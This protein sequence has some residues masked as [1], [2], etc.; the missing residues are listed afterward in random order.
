MTDLTESELEEYFYL[1]LEERLQ[2]LAMPAGVQLTL[3]PEGSA[4]VDELALEFDDALDMK[5]SAK[6]RRITAEQQALLDQ[7]DSTFDEMSGPKPV[8]TEEALRS[9]S[10]WQA[11]RSLAKQALEA[12]GW[13]VQAPLWAHTYTYSKD[14]RISGSN[15]IS[16]RHEELKLKWQLD[17]ERLQKRNDPSD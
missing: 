8:W 4:K 1:C 5:W 15:T 13:E 7:I 6:R 16:T 9:S 17:R 12:F 2:A 11:V 3:F 10:Q 14:G